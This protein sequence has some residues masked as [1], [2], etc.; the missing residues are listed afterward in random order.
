MHTHIHVYMHTYICIHIH[1]YMHAYTHIYL[2]GHEDGACRGGIGTREAADG[3]GMFKG[4]DLAE[5]RH[6]E[7]EDTF[8]MRRRIHVYMRDQGCSKVKTSLSVD[9]WRRRI[10]FI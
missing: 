2:Y 1:T 7:E 5:R 6:L 3:P 4:K 8:H 9:T 10:H